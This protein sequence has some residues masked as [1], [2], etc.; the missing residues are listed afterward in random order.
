MK[1]GRDLAQSYDKSLNNKRQIK[2]SNVT[3]QKRI[4]TLITQ[5]LLTDFGRSVGVTATTQLVRL[6]QL[7]DTQPSH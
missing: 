2:K 3:T 7:T 6:N 5:R 4:K 1:N